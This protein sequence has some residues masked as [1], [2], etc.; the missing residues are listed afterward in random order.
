MLSYFAGCEVLTIH[1]FSTPEMT[2]IWRAP[3]KITVDV[4]VFEDVEIMILGLDLER[5]E[6]FSKQLS[7]I[8]NLT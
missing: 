5:A 2:T 4:L 3:L 1:I 7:V 8:A 6:G